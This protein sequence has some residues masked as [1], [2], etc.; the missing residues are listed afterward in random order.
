VSALR[1]SSTTSL[2][3]A[4]QQT[5]TNNNS[6]SNNDDGELNADTNN[7]DAVENDQNKEADVVSAAPPLLSRKSSITAAITKDPFT[8]AI[9]EKAGVKS[10]D[11]ALAEAE[12][13]AEAGTESLPPTAPSPAV[14]DPVDDAVAGPMGS[15]NDITTPSPPDPLQDYD[16]SLLG[17]LMDNSDIVSGR[18]KIY[19][20]VR[21]P[22]FPTPTS[23]ITIS[24][25][26]LVAM[27][28]KDVEHMW[29]HN[30]PYLVLDYAHGVWKATTT[31]IDNAGSEG[32]WNFPL[33]EEVSKDTHHSTEVGDEQVVAKKDSA[34]QTSAKQDDGTTIAGVEFEKQQ[35][36]ERGGADAAQAK[37]QGVVEAL[38]EKSS[39]HSNKQ[40]VKQKQRQKPKP[41]MT[42]T[43]PAS[44][45]RSKE[46]VVTAM[47]QNH[48][49]P[50][51]FI[52]VGAIS[53]IP[54]IE[55]PEVTKANL[56][57]RTLGIMTRK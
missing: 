21:R 31:A 30:D 14:A 24:V 32:E 53:L 40:K 3:E 47:D 12:A 25:V 17:H 16:Y 28:L 39:K 36:S 20:R 2:E 54:L 7:K 49:R 46:L 19:F 34:N 18:V 9:E 22:V 52:G 50:D 6:G 56:L 42:F 33:E 8:E 5:T 44:V 38:T 55:D 15:H 57:M 45:I 1:Q 51:V 26:K 10:E 13:E 48:F 35:G 29:H 27:E 43:V 4:A 23:D 11:T 37:T 41:M